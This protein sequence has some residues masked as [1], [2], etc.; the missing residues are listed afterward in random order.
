MNADNIIMHKDWIVKKAKIS[1]LVAFVI[2][3]VSFPALSLIVLAD[4][5]DD[6]VK[7]GDQELSISDPGDE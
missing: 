6:N 5:A 7:I 1:L 3:L 4:Y 2:S